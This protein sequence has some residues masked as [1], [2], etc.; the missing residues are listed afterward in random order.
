MENSNSGITYITFVGQERV[1]N[2]LDLMIPE[3]KG[4]RNINILFKAQSGYGK[5]TLAYSLAWKIGNQSWDNYQYIL[6]NDE[7]KIEIDYSKRV[8][9]LDEVHTF[10]YPETLYPLMDSKKYIFI[11]CTNESGNLKEPLMNR[12]MPFIF[13]EYTFWE[14]DFLIK[15]LFKKNHNLILPDEVSKEITANS[16]LNPRVAKMGLVEPLSFIF[17][18]QGI[19]KTR[20]ETKEIIK[21]QLDIIDGLNLNHRNYLEL[22]RS[23]D[24]ASISTI[25]A[26]LNLDRSTVMNYVEPALIKR[27]LIRITS[28]G[29]KLQ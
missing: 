6:P 28:R 12:C 19:P 21:V 17:K 29:R 14:I 9:I 23:V 27:K 3:L 4:G 10:K 2:L 15:D 5:T 22:L 24:T 25:C 13:D 18:N 26:Y 11:L 7:G 16:N 20:E 1:R 8:I